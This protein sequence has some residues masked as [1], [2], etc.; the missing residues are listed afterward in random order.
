MK[1]TIS[2]FFYMVKQITQEMMMVMLV[3]APFLA[4]VCFKFGIPAIE[5]TILK[6]FGLQDILIPY[7]DWFSWLLAM[8]I[9]M[10][11]AFV[12]GLVV[13]GEIDDRIAK[14]VMVTPAGMKGYLTSRIFLPALLSGIVACFC[15]PIFALTKIDFLTLLVMI[16]S[17]M[18]SGMVTAFLVVAISSNKVEGMATGKLSGFFG[19]TFFFPLFIKGWARYLFFA[20]PMFWIGEWSVNGR[21]YCLIFAFLEYVIW[22]YAL[23]HR[24]KRKIGKY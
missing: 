6:H 11:F 5:N 17:T 12:G 20:F 16:S 24:F 3:T 13:L 19:I 15:V 22:M 21:W 10:L 23:F 4:G 18:L 14:Y 1:A 7:Y 9:G 8:L 2:M